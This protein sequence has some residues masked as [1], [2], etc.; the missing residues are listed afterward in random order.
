MGLCMRINLLI[1][2][3]RDYCSGF[4]GQ[5]SFIKNLHP[6]L[7]QEY[8]LKYLILSEAFQKQNIIP[9][10]LLYFLKVLFFLI[11]RRNKYDFII[12]HTP[13]A[14]F[15]VSFFKIPFIHIF[16]G[17]ANP[18]SM[19]TFWYGKYFRWIFNYF[20]TRITE[21]ARILY[22]VGE[23]RKDARK[24]YAP[25]SFR[26]DKIL[27]YSERKDFVF[28]GRLENVKNIDIII[29]RYNMLPS[30]IKESN[31]LHIIGSGSR[32]NSP[33]ILVNEL[34]LDEN[35]VFHGL[36]KNEMAIDIMSHSLIML[37]ASSFEGFPMAIAES[38][39][40]GTPV[41]TTNV[42]DIQSVIKDGFN[43]YLLSKDFT[44]EEF[45]EK[46]MN[47]LTDY[48]YFSGN[49]VKSSSVFNAA[50]VAESLISDC[51]EII[52]KQNLVSL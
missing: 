41:V 10:R 4:G 17:N 48:E 3:D 44:S 38:L 49:A 6:Y 29:S 32:E 52:A 12:S 20:E 8:S 42:G 34:H 27:P 47:I 36:I 7:K 30:N 26:P 23:F 31:K 16:H 35:V 24:I 14:S 39:T 37:M 2:N 46:I 19:S 50:K 15:V 1:L 11:R 21:K 18:L 13:E 40:V 22:T 5:S 9:V 25:I 28:S 45:N 43:G 51:N 33:K